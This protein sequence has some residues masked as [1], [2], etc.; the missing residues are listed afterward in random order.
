MYWQKSSIIQR[1]FSSSILTLTNHRAENFYLSSV[2]LHKRIYA[3]SV[4]QESSMALFF[5]YKTQNEGIISKESENLHIKR[6]HRIK[7]V[8]LRQLRAIGAKKSSF[9]MDQYTNKHDCATLMVNRCRVSSLIAQIVL[10]RL[11][12]L[13]IFLIYKILDWIMLHIEKDC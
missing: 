10:K 5:T 6:S 12:G 1:K 11:T 9:G 13:I 7:I 8:L 2:S 4:L 3:S